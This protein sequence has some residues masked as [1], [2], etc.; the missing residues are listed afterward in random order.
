MTCPIS[1]WLDFSNISPNLDL[2]TL[3][4]RD[5]RLENI[6]KVRM[7][8]AHIQP[9]MPKINIANIKVPALPLSVRKWRI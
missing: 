1:R 2:W 9:P 8:T 3:P 4:R 7:G 5:N 6:K